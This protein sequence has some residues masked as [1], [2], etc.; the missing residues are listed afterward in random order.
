MQ[1]LPPA[2]GALPAGASG[3]Q[4]ERWEDGSPVAAADVIAQEVP[5]AIRYGETPYAVM[6][7]SPLDLEDFALGF[8]L[9]EGLITRAEDITAIEIREDLAGVLLDVTL[10]PE[11]AA[12]VQAERR[13]LVSNSSCGVCGT[14]LLEEAIR[15]PGR[16]NDAQHFDMRAVLHAA[17]ALRLRQPLFAATGAVHAA[18]WC[19]PS[20][21]PTLSREDVGRHNA[22]DKLIGARLKAGDYPGGF[23]LVS[24]R[25]SYEMVQKVAAAGIGLMAAVSAP[26]TLAVRMAESAGI[27]LIGF[28][29]GGRAVVY[30]HAARLKHSNNAAA[31]AAPRGL[32]T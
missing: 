21:T 1:N 9:T 16:V 18:A 17:E 26:T 24:S 27:T 28:A 12:R 13:T 31:P 19:E 29:R 2:A 22:L 14:R 7:G 23:V 3:V 10:V 5:I 6:M 8:S 30:S 15:W 20:G 4:V 25:A 32:Q 11:A